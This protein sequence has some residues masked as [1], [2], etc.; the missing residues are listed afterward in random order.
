MR[1]KNML[2]GLL[3]ATLPA[4]ALVSAPQPVQA[5]PQGPGFCP[6]GLRDKGC[7]PPG[8]Q[9]KFHRGDHIPDWVVY[10]RVHYRDYGL[11]APRPGHHYISVGGDVYLVA[12]AT[13]RVIEAINLLGA[14]GR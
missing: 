12:E 9:K 13:Q 1:L 7:V 8:L 2:G 11:P 5:G 14:V 3:L 4:L 6:P 10:D